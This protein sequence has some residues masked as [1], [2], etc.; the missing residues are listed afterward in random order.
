LGGGRHAGRQPGN[1]GRLQGWING[2]D[3]EGWLAVRDDWLGGFAGWEERS[4]G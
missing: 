3:S 4:R 1:A 2:R